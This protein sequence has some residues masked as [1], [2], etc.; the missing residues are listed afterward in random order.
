MVGPNRDKDDS[1]LGFK[2]WTFSTVRCW[3]ESPVGTFQLFVRDKGNQGDGL[4][5][6]WKLTLYGS[7]WSPKDVRERRIEVENSYSGE[8]I[9]PARNFSLHCPPGESLV[10]DITT[11]MSDRTLKL[12]AL[13]SG[14][15]LNNDFS[16]KSPTTVIV[17]I[18][19]GMRLFDVHIVRKPHQSVQR[20]RP[21]GRRTQL[22]LHIQLE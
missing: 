5:R 15:F 12:I 6:Y 10:F 22:Y 16:P 21:S 17:Q 18:H 2:D 3:G 14:K 7:A 4:L 20:R 8:F 13:M 11:T 19:G 1:D 9:D